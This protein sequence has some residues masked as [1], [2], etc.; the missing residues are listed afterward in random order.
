MKQ[1]IKSLF[2]KIL[3]AKLR[4]TLR[5]I[6][7]CP[8]NYR[9]RNFA[10]L[11]TWLHYHVAKK[12]VPAKLLSRK[13]FHFT[14]VTSLQRYH[15]N[16][17]RYPDFTHPTL[18]SE[19]VLKC[20]HTTCQSSSLYPLL[21]DKYRVRAYVRKLLGS[22]ENLIPLI[23]DFA[24][25]QAFVDAYIANPDKYTNSVVKVNHGYAQNFFIGNQA[26]N[27]LEL[28]TLK[29]TLERWMQRPHTGSYERHY[30]RITPHITEEKR[31]GNRETL[32]ELQIPHA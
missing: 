7:H 4:Q 3:P 29:E 11:P 30:A 1:Q 9:T 5:S 25:A 20:I 24:S 23:D 14:A 32:I 10:A 8:R 15:A 16:F 17:G 13:Y 31:L 2:K 21:A 27:N 12:V 26:L 28:E 22:E 18:F 19:K 6:Q